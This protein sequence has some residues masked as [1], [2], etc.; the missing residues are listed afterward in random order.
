MFFV[1]YRGLL[2][3]HPN[4][5]AGKVVSK[6]VQDP[7]I[8]AVQLSRRFVVLWKRVKVPTAA[9]E[10]AVGI[11]SGLR[12]TTPRTRQLI[13][14]PASTDSEP[15]ARGQRAVGFGTP[16]RAAS[17]LDASKICLRI[18][19]ATSYIYDG[20]NTFSRRL[21]QPRPFILPSVSPSTQALNTY[22]VSSTFCRIVS[23]Q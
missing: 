17:A 3:I 19:Q 21:R 1:E 6:R 7:V 11:V 14:L 5:A 16:T 20:Q 12:H 9:A 8:G 18:D 4:L 2:R 23:L 10:A 15:H 13:D 22:I